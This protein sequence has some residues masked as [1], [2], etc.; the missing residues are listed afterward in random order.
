MPFKN[1]IDGST[2]SNTYLGLNALSAIT[3]GVGNVAVGVNALLKV[4][5]GQYNI[6]I[7]QNALLTNTIGNYNTAIGQNAL[8]FNLSGGNNTAVGVGALTNN[9]GSDNVAVGFSALL[10]NLA[11]SSNVAVGE[12][13]LAQNTSGTNNTALGQGAGL[14]IISGTNNTLLGNGANASG[15]VSNEITLGNSSVSK[16]R[17]QV[18]SITALSDFRDK[19]NVAPLALGLGFIKAL[20]PVTFTWQTRDGAKVGDL[21]LGFIAQ[22]LME[23]EDSLGV[24]P[25]TQLTLRTNPDKYEATPGRLIPILVRAIQDL[26]AKVTDLESRL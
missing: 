23:L 20:K 15:D 5:T 3:T 18:T 4:T 1:P 14:F 6:A 12:N 22:D 19:K 21:D 17:C 8:E 25:Y 24:T 7:G 13:T 9:T 11:G 26:S 16:L 2:T 10:N